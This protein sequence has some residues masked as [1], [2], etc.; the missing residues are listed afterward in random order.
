VL[1]AATIVAVNGVHSGGAV[2]SCLRGDRRG[3]Y[4]V[5]GVCYYRSALNRV[6]D[7]PGKRRARGD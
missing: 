2:V 6:K 5:V 1:Y 7:N 3:R 4:R